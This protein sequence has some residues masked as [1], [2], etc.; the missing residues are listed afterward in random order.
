MI[1]RIKPNTVGGKTIG[2]INKLSNTLTHE[3]LRRYNHLDIKI[4]KTVTIIVLITATRMDIQKVLSQ[5][6]I[7][8]PYAAKWYS[9]NISLALSDFKNS[10]HS[11]ANLL[12]DVA[13]TSYV[14][15]FLSSTSL[16]TFTVS[17]FCFVYISQFYIQNLV[18]H[19]PFQ[20]NLI[21]VLHL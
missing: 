11:F 15:G 19:Y 4:P 17:I 9:F 2:N 1:N 13:P 3:P 8:T 20:H 18:S 14:I 10:I 16:I 6:W 7:T 12:S 21:L 5:A